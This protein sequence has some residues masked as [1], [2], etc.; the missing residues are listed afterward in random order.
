MKEKKL[1]DKSIFNT[2]LTRLLSEKVLANLFVV[3]ELRI[4]N[5]IYYPHYEILWL[6]TEYSLALVQFLNISFSRADVYFELMQHS[7]LHTC[8]RM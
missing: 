1:S 7:Q 6:S 4:L 8:R 5:K 3:W 2:K